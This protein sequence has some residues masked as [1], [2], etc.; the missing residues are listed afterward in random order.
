MRLKTFLVFFLLVPAAGASPNEIVGWVE[1][2]A[3]YG[4]HNEIIMKAKIDTGAQ[5]TS[6]HSKNYELFSKNGKRW[7]KFRIFNKVGDSLELEKPVVRMAE[8]KRHFGKKQVRPVI[9]LGLCLGSNYKIT[10]VNLVDRSGFNYQLLVGREYLK[11]NNIVDPSVTY[12]KKP[13]CR[14][15]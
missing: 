8:I 12:T 3:I 14:K 15:R 10:E 9:H 1:H 13:D 4:D 6:I 2:V 5:T 11:P 7:V